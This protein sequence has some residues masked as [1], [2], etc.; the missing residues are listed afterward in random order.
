LKPELINQYGSSII[1]AARNHPQGA[2]AVPER[3]VLVGDLAFMGFQR[4]PETEER[5]LLEAT[6]EL[7]IRH[8]LCFREM[9]YLVFP[10][11]ISVSRHSHTGTHP[12]TEVAYRFSGGI[13]TIY[14][15]LVVRLNYTD[16][17]HREDQWKYAVEFSRNGDRLGFSMHQVEEGT[18][19]L[20]VYFDSGISEV[21]RV[22]FI[23]FVTDHLRTK[24]IDIKEQ[25]RLY[26]PKC[27]KEVTNHEAIAA[28]VDAGF[29]DIPCQYCATTILIPRSIEERYQRDP[30]LGEKQEQLAITVK[31]RTVAE[32]EQFRADQHQYTQAEDPNIHILHL[33]DLHCEDSACSDLYRAQLETDLIRELGVRRLEYVVI[34]GDIANRSI[35][36][37][38]R[39]AFSMLDSLVKH[40]GLDSSRIIIVPGNHDVNWMLSKKA[41]PFVYTEDLPSPLSDDSYIPAGPTGAL[42]RDDSLYGERFAY[43][44]NHFFKRVYSGREYPLDYADQAI[45]V[46]RPDDRVLF[47]G[48]NSSWQVDHC[49]Q[50]RASIHPQSLAKTLDRCLHAYDGWLKIA[51]W[52]HPVS[53]K[54][55]MNDHFLQLLA[56][57]G[58]Q[59]CLHGHI[60]EAIDSFHV[61]D[62]RRQIRIIGAGTFGAEASQQVVGI[63]LQYNLLTLDPYKGEIVVH[64]RKKEKLDGAWSADARWGDRN[65]PKPCYGFTVEGYS[66]RKKD[67]RS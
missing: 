46:E 29:L 52:H 7:L 14:A 59:I 27:S 66:R 17:F 22:T 31:R 39:V 23:R 5:L 67:G 32:L 9:G 36:K 63:P 12:R 24:G 19:E 38:Y 30:A 3:D 62:E 58:F 10:S 21:D 33:S 45:F 54:E 57:H 48:F 4:L 61:Y 28:R 13:E 15:S 1:Q 44:S 18:G 34:S 16:Y 56:V 60:H 37:E 20:E 6:V 25:I 35:E 47:V 40:F 50:D 42:V 2:G 55:M 43:F 41:Y 26:C 11:Q 51:V 53:G 65:D 64:T 49:F 8:G